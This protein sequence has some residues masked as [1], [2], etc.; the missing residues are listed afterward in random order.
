MW[1][2]AQSSIVAKIFP[3]TTYAIEVKGNL[4]SAREPD[5]SKIPLQLDLVVNTASHLNE[6][7]TL[8]VL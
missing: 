1:K 4:Q 5:Q 6:R 2:T 3:V 7:V 8:S